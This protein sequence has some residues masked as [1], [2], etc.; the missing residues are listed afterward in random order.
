MTSINTTEKP[1]NFTDMSPLKDW[2]NLFAV[3]GGGGGGGERQSKGKKIPSECLTLYCR[4]YKLY[5]PEWH[6]G[7][8][9]STAVLICDQDL[10]SSVAHFVVKE[11]SFFSDHSPVITWLNIETNICNK[12]VVHANDTL[13]R[14]PRHFCWENDSTKNS[15]TRYGPR[16][17]H[18]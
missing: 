3:Y 2:L 10:Y 15:K 9:C 12:N 11:L 1:F 4:P 14:L 6:F 18:D 17:H 16:A 7:S 5:P 8:H 13:K